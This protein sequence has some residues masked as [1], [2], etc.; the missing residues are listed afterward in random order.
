[1]CLTCFKDEASLTH[2]YGPL[3]RAV[4]HSLVPLTAL[5]AV[6]RSHPDTHTHTQ[7][8][9]TLYSKAPVVGSVILN[10]AFHSSSSY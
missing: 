4:Q 5:R 8:R 6:K 10:A 3:A 7:G 1:M 9:Q 2:Q